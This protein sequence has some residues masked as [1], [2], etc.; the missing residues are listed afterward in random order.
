M[1]DSGLTSKTASK[2]GDIAVP[3]QLRRSIGTV[4]AVADAAANG[5]IFRSA[6]VSEDG[7]R[8]G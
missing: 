3:R 2:Y 6:P 1:I 4:Q 7:L 5:L 8:V